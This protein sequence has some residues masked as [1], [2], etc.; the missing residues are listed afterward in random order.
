MG[1][2]RVSFKRVDVRNERLFSIGIITVPLTIRSGVFA[3]GREAT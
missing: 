2:A 1:I 3:V